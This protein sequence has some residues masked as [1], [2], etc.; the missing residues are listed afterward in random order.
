MPLVLVVSVVEDSPFSSFA[1][2]T[3]MIDIK[4][5]LRWT[6]NLPERVNVPTLRDTPPISRGQERLIILCN[7]YNQARA[8][9]KISI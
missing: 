3:A 2:V 9:K 4:A 5:S 8:G 1:F 6:S 7:P